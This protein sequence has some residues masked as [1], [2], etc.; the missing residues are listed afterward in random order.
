MFGDATAVEDL[1]L[2]VG[3]GRSLWL[4]W[5]KW[6]RE[7]HD[8]RMLACLISKTSGEAR[9]GE[10]EVGDDADVQKIRKI[11]GLDA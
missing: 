6:R 5:T 3:R 4:S 11:I 2:H 1:T 8:G 10:Y 9:I 7:D